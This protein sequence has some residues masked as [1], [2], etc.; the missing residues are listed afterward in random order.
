MAYLNVAEKRVEACVAYVGP[1]RAGKRGNLERLRLRGGSPA[2][3]VAVGGEAFA[4]ELEPGA[5]K[6]GDLPVHVRV[7]GQRAGSGIATDAML[8]DVDGVVVVL[9][10][11]PSA[12]ARNLS[13]VMEVR[14]AL[15]E[16][17]TPV[18]V[19]V[20]KADLPDALPAAD[21]VA[22]VAATEWPHV[23]ASVAADVGVEETFQQVVGAVMQSI[24][25]APA[26]SDRASL[27]ERRA[28]GHPL[29]SALRRVLET[30]AEQQANALSSE[31]AARVERRIDER[32]QVLEA[33]IDTLAG[34]NKR[35]VAL[36]SATELLRAQLGS[37]NEELLKAARHACSRE[38]LAAATAD[39]RTEIMHVSAAD[40]ERVGRVEALLNELIEELRKPK[41]GWFG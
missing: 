37:A 22:S 23:S 36:E 21:L 11:A 7:V 31:L 16:R 10:A 6:L 34:M 19:Q 39:V 28:D 9:D 32:L 12:H 41:K 25:A 38:D 40:Q 27:P 5:A 30:T 29:L 24:A 20:N 4:I 18:V 33:R 26:E 35:I 2:E 14:S 8:H 1:R 13:V 3:L 17:S 15:R